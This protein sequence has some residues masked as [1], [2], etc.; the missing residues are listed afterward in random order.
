MQTDRG[1]GESEGQPA[2]HQQGEDCQ[3]QG[4]LGQGGGQNSGGPFAPDPL[5]PVR[6]YPILFIVIVP[7]TLALGCSLKL[8][9]GNREGEQKQK[10]LLLWLFTPTA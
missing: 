9:H 3:R 6:A 10:V 2:P 5:R 4:V 1:V 8:N 7:F